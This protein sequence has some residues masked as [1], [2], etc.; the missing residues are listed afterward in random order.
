MHRK[1]SLVL[2]LALAAALGLVAAGCGGG[3]K[4][5]ATTKAATTE[6]ATTTAAAG[7]TTHETTTEAMTHETTT[8]AMTHETTTAAAGSSLGSLAGKCKG[9]SDLGR[10]FSSA[11]TG[12]ANGKDLKKEASLLHEFAEQTPSEIRP[13]F[14]VVADYFSKI[15]DVTGNLKTGQTPDPQTLAKLQKLSTEIDQTKLTAASQHITAWV[16]KNCR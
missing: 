3:S 5:A 10:K 16:T 15:A 1:S 9:L 6:A 14:R 12:A 13:D 11:F 4:S 7:A 8:E 2:C